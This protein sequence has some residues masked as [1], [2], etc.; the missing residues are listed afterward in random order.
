MHGSGALLVTSDGR[1]LL[2][3]RDLNP[4]IWFPGYWGLFGGG[5][6]PGESAE[7]ALWRELAEELE[8]APRPA[9]FFCQVLFDVGDPR[10]Y[11]Y[12]RSLFVVP[13]EA[14]EV[15]GLPLHEGQGMRLFAPEDVRREPRIVPYDL[16]GLEMYWH[17]ESWR[18]VLPPEPVGPGSSARSD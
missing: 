7:S 15:E 10:G 5:A 9:R 1:T 16:F 11:V 17:R 18:H 13:I 12:G 3:H 4:H 6:E 8:L 14:A 2:Q